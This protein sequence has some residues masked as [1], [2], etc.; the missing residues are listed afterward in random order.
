[1]K[2]YLCK[3]FRKRMIFK[4]FC[5]IFRIFNS[6]RSSLKNINY[7]DKEYFEI[8]RVRFKFCN[9]CFSKKILIIQRTK[10]ESSESECA[11]VNFFSLGK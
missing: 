2:A 5:K 8:M 4:S 11:L 6:Y 7:E 10:K 1:M 9:F 3:S